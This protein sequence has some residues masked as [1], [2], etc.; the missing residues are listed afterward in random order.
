MCSVSAVTARHHSPREQRPRFEPAGAEPVAIEEVRVQREEHGQ[1]RRDVPQDAGAAL[2]DFLD[3]PRADLPRV[4]VPV[5]RELRRRGRA[6][7]RAA[8]RAPSRRTP[9]WR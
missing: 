1:Q 6:P 9:G 8:P 2:A 7:C 3:R 4:L 5:E